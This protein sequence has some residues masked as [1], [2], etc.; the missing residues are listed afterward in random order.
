[1][2]SHKYTQR[3]KFYSYTDIYIHH[4]Y[5]HIFKIHKIN[6]KFKARDTFYYYFFNLKA[7][8]ILSKKQKK[9]KDS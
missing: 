5:T 9:Y 3:Y 2:K 4:K 7:Y 8:K 1:M 6:I